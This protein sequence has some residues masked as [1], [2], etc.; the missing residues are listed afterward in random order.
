[1]E[2]R[3]AGVQALRKDGQIEWGGLPSA[4]PRRTD[5]LC[6]QCKETWVQPLCGEDPLE[7]EWQAL[8]SILDWRIPWTEEPG[9]LYSPWGCK[10]L[11]TTEHP[12]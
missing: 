12:W 10:E 5:R 9:E 2:V 7:K 6:L 4:D 8:S 11:D 1:M 3:V